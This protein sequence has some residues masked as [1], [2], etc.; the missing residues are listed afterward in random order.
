MITTQIRTIAAVAAALAASTAVAACGS[1]N[2]SGPSQAQVKDAVNAVKTTSGQATTPTQT[3]PATPLTT[4]TQAT[5]TTTTTTQQASADGKA[6]FTQ[7]CASCHTLKAAGA[8]G[9]V[10]PNLDTLKPSAATVAG[11]VTK[12]GGGMPAFAGQLSPAEI[13]A[14]AAYVSSSAGG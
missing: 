10:G 4:T 2:S 11:Q 12:G 7:N 1:S 8:S 5:T 3:T 9:A 6:I 13:K 14:V